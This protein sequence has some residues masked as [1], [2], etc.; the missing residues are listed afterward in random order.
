MASS[1][2]VESRMR[3]FA[4]VVVVVISV[5]PTEAQ[6]SNVATIT[7][8]GIYELAGLFMRFY[9][10]CPVLRADTPAIKASRL[11]LCLITARTLRLGLSLLGIRVLERM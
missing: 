4:M 2:T 5:Q 8:P 9:E 11:R 1:M 3:L 10:H 6:Q 7:E